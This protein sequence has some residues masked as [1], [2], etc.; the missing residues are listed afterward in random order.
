MTNK[1]E[2][3]EKNIIHEHRLE[4]TILMPCLNEAETIRICVEKAKFF[5]STY[6]VSG[7][8][9]VADNGSTDGSR[10]IAE[11][12]GARV[13]VVPEKGYGAALI[14]GNLAARG[15][16]CIMGDADNSYN[17]TEL[18]PFLEKLREGYDLVMGNRF[19]GGIGKG[20]MPALHKY[21]GNPVLSTIGK[22][23]YPSDIGD[24]HC[25]LRGYNTE[26][27][28]NLGLRTLG[29]E[30][31]S[32]MVVQAALHGLRITEV[33]IILHP[34]GRSRPPHLRSWSDGW[35]HLKYLLMHAPNWLFYVP[36]FFMF[37]FGL[38]GTVLL[39][40]FEPVVETFGLN[41]LL[42]M[43][44]ITVAGFNIL[45]F[46]VVAKVY[47]T[48]SKFIPMSHKEK[49]YDKI[50]ANSGSLAGGSMIFLGVAG[51]LMT[52][53]MWNSR[54]FEWMEVDIAMRITLPSVMLIIIGLN[55]IL[56]SFLVDILRIKVRHGGG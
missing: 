46:G 39:T 19:K 25:G 29:M 15:K 6:E 56:T 18:M 48:Q 31:A 38:T 47:A 2:Q 11:K 34:D 32:E 36:G 33:P 53:Y 8:V 55:I 52:L 54:F 28:K 24:F 14:G 12:C 26:A 3:D 27:I 9:L 4:L 20:A 5:L 7:E 10:E 51:T 13:V 22:V 41:T 49:F 21:L 43:V 23:L 16:Y 35:R 40:L 30:Y 37:I 45:S 1:L 17:F 50:N 42:Y 44:V